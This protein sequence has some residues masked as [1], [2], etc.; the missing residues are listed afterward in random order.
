M[1]LLRLPLSQHYGQDFPIIQYVDDTIL[2]MEACPKQLFFLK[3]ILNS[4]AMSTGLHVNYQKPNIYPINLSLD[5]MVTLAI[6]FGCSVGTLPFTYLGLPMGTTK[7][8][9]AAFMPLIHKIEKRLT[10]TSTFLSLE[11]KLQI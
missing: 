10:S 8:N 2:I 6:T 7:P 3:A 5:R 1:G 9:L 11:G 4:F